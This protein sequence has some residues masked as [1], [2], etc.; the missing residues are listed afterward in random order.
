MAAIPTWTVPKNPPLIHS[1]APRSLLRHSGYGPSRN[2]S[3]AGRHG[4]V[5]IFKAVLVVPV[6][7]LLLSVPGY[8]MLIGENVPG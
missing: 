1:C 5:I 4:S 8:C 6:I 3:G 2:V 7:V